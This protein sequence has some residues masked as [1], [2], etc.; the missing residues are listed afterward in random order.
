M[1]SVSYVF[2]FSDKCIKNY[3]RDIQYHITPIGSLPSN[4]TVWTKKFLKT[5]FLTLKFGFRRLRLAN[6]ISD[7]LE[8]RKKLKFFSLL[9]T[10]IRSLAQRN[11][12]NGDKRDF[13]S[14][15][16]PQLLTIKI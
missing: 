5:P 1:L 16:G 10:S 2:L 7:S 15:Y 6:K 12:D 14:G 9:L 8:Q 4:L 3:L 11:E 13:F